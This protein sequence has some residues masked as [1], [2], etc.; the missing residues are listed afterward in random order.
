MVSGV[1]GWCGRVW[2]LGYVHLMQDF[3]QNLVFSFIGGVGDIGS[4]P[5][6]MTQI[7]T[8]FGHLRGL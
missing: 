1:Q 7:I 5:V 2:G 6:R 8:I 4:I 3:E